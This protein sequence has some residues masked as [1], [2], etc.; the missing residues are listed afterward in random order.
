MAGT[1][2]AGSYRLLLTRPFVLRTFALG[3]VGRLTYGVLPLPLLFT[4]RQ[5]TGSFAVAAFGTALFGLG[6]LTMPVQARLI[7][8]HGQRR[9]LPVA[10]TLF[11]LGLTTM[12]VLSIRGVSTPLAWIALAGCLG[13]TAP[14]LGP[15]MRAQWR[16]F[17]EED[18][19]PAAYAMDSVAEESLYLLGPLVASIVLALGPA[20]VGLLVA[21][22]LLAVGVGGLVASPAAGPGG[23]LHRPA[24]RSFLW[25]RRLLALLAAMAVSGAA[26]ASAYT[27]VAA[28]AD[29][30]DHPEYAG[31]VEIAMA[32]GAVTGGIA[33]GRFARQG[34]WATQL[35][36]LF[37][38]LAVALT[39]CFLAGTLV[40]IAVALGLG[41]LVVSPAYVVAFTAS[42]SLVP[43]R[44]RTEA[45]TWVS[46]SANLGTSAGTALAGVLVHRFS[47]GAPFALGAVVLMVAAVTLCAG[48]RRD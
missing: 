32:L 20:R 41:S 6:T 39:A 40:P 19:R 34:H 23:A 8:R 29:A 46:T 24:D 7:D 47:P 31:Y 18:A 48:R 13:P 43:D 21:L 33:W 38:V 37:V 9:V 36:G 2:R 28:V 26:T 12:V 25:S 11:M 35:A 14:A 44:Q 16:V 10:A 42:D 15:S 22:G 27:A 17:V 5:A 30:Q 4:I 3:L 45:S 1:S